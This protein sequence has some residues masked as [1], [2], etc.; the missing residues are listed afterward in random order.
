MN[1]PAFE[2]F[3]VWTPFAERSWLLYS[4]E[5]QDESLLGG[6]HRKISGNDGENTL[7]VTRRD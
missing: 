1:F 7:F 2:Y 4:T 6:I 5:I 3:R